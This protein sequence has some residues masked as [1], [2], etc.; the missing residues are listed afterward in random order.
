[1][2][3]I[4]LGPCLN[5][6]EISIHCGV[7]LSAPFPF[8]NGGAKEAAISSKNR[9]PYAPSQTRDANP[10]EVSQGGYGGRNRGKVSL[11]CI[12]EID[13]SGGEIKVIEGSEPFV[14]AAKTAVAQWKYEP[15][16]L[17]GVAAQAD[18]TID[19]IF[20]I[21]KSK[22]NGSASVGAHKLTLE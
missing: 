1:M 7:A 2:E 5:Y 9:L 21:L 13:G 10:T 19:V 3:R 17:N 16:V 12:V 8:W 15:I 4:P 11:R 18:T 22:S 14:Q 6:G 20:Q